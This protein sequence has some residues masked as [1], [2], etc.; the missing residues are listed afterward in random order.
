[1]GV[2]VHLHD[3]FNPTRRTVY[4]L[5]RQVTVRRLVQRHKGLR[6]FTQVYRP[7]GIYGRRKVREFIRNA[8]QA[9]PRPYTSAEASRPF[10]WEIEPY[11]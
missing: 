2:L 3:R 4:R 5:P 11:L 10:D 6:P 1:M 8:K 7:G 9:A